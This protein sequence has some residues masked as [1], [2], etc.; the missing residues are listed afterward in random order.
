MKSFR[1][2]HRPDNPKILKK[3]RPSDKP[4]DDEQQ[5][6][7]PHA[8]TS[9]LPLSSLH[10][11]SYQEKL[12]GKLAR[13]QETPTT[14]PVDL[15][16]SK[17]MTMHFRQ[18]DPLCLE[19]QI[20]PS[21]KQQLMAPWQQAIIVKVLGRT[22]GYKVLYTHVRQLWEPKGDM[23]NLDLGHGYFLVKFTAED[24][25]NLKACPTAPPIS[26]VLAPLPLSTEES[27]AIHCPAPA[28]AVADSHRD[29]TDQTPRYGDW[30][31][32]ARRPRCAPRPLPTATLHTPSQQ[33]NPNRYLALNEEITASTEEITA[34]QAPLGSAHATNV[35]SHAATVASTF[36]PLSFAVQG[37]SSG[38]AFTSHMV[39]SLAG[40]LQQIFTPAM[41][42]LS[43]PSKSPG[44]DSL[45]P[46]P[47]D[48]SPLV[49]TEGGGVSVMA[50]VGSPTPQAAMEVDSQ[51]SETH[52]T[53]T[54]TDGLVA[55]ALVEGLAD[56]STLVP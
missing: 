23:D 42:P 9:A 26:T 7:A 47:P 53:T 27:D 6:S 54:V 46:D 15:L 49:Q 39:H 14:E 25:R 16:A 3:S 33:E 17:S 2:L 8:S 11:P 31:I 44:D 1:Y 4:L 43:E 50:P 20:D 55:A 10:V 5:G 12:L 52:D 41:P 22:V 34:F 40:T 32:V 56:P 51:T 45:S 30:M 19:F 35:A 29:M 36:A 37:V 13:Q 38:A 24:D 18:N 28:L 21:F 48:P